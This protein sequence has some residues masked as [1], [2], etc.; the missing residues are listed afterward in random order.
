MRVVSLRGQEFIEQRFEVP[1]PVVIAGM[2]SMGDGTQFAEGNRK[3]VVDH[4]IV[5]LVAVRN[6]ATGSGKPGL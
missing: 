4:Q 6:F 3:V 1:T 2:L 5:V